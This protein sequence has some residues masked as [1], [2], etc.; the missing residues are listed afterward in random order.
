MEKRRREA[1]KAAADGNN[2]SP[3]AS[4]SLGAE[5]STTRVV[6]T[7]V[8]DTVDAQVLLAFQTH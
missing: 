5:S 7:N 3:A 4:P 8:E 6:C 2:A 1:A